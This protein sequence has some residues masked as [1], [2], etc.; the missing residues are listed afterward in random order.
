MVKF[1]FIT[2]RI[3]S[4]TWKKDQNQSLDVEMNENKIKIR[5]G[6]KQNMK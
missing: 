3:C 6:S 5:C 2:D 1:K 4:R